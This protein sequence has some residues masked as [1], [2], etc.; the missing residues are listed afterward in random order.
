MMTDP[1]ADMLARIRNAAAR[2]GT[3]ARLSRR[4]GPKLAIARVLRRAP[5]SSRRAHVEAPRGQR[6]SLAAR[7]SA[8]RRRRAAACSTGC[9]AFR[10]RAAACTSATDEMP[11]VRDG[12]G[13][14]VISTSQGILSDRAARD[15]DDRRRAPLRGL[16]RCRGSDARPIAIPN[17]VTV[18][19]SRRRG[20]REGPEGPARRAACRRGIEIAVE[21]GQARFG[22]QRRA[23]DRARVPRA[24]ARDGREHGAR[25]DAGLRARARDRGRRLSRRGVGQEAHARARLL[26]PGRA[27][28][29]PRAS[30]SPVEGTTRSRSRASD[31]ERS[32]SS[33]PSCASSGRPS[34]TRA[35]ASATR[36]STSAA[37]SA[38]PGG[39]LRRR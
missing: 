11:R 30:R 36:T 21:D 32:A 3:R 34:R 22:A 10:G 23:Q 39:R 5:A 9:A 19:Q 16:V 15:A 4:R 24:R 26:A 28:R 18:E 35:R 37:R 14:A 33:R 25:R 13:V 8:L 17:G 27:R 29:C 1:I 38:R 31:R 7:A 12:L 2:R 20:A 6:A